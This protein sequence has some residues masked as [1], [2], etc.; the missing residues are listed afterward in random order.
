MVPKKNGKW[1]ICMDYR[2][3]NKEM[4]KYHFPFPFIDQVF[5]TLAGKKFFYF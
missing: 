1:W 4:Q 3:L 5:D 2:E